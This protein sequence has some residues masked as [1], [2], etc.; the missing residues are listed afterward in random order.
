MPALACEAIDDGTWCVDTGLYRL[1]HTAC[2]L[3]ADDGELA[4]VDCGSS[5]NI[6]DLIET[7]IELGYTA[8]QVRYVMPTHV[9]LDHAGGAG[10]LMAACPN[11][12]LVTHARGA[13]HLIDP[14]RLQEGATAVYGE[15]GFEQAFGS[16]IP[17]RGERVV[18]AA[19]G[20]RYALGRRH[21]CFADTPGHANHHGCFFDERTA[22]WFTGDTFGLSYREF[23]TDAGPLLLAT[24]TPVA[25]N[26]D[27]WQ[28]SLDK[29]M[30]AEPAGMCLTHFGR[31]VNPVAACRDLRRNITAHATIA[32][33]DEDRSDEGRAKRL[34]QAVADLLLDAAVGH[35]PAMPRE[36]AARLLA[37]DIDLNAQGLHIWLTRRAKAAASTP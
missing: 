34:R 3:I 12:T 15:E 10:A 24:T 23:D 20:A 18:A 5:N 26:P 29:L 17:V 8:E 6:P 7:L 14:T 33:A 37:L 11:A 31:I 19:D 27:A 16:L 2:Y 32:L 9:H 13:P 21:I 22:L 30:A 35:Q 36:Q 4:I 28:R 1:G 25:F